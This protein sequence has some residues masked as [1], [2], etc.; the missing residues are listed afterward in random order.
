MVTELNWVLHVRAFP[1]LTVKS[2][3]YFNTTFEGDLQGKYLGIKLRKSKA[4]SSSVQ[5]PL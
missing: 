1:G 5:R 4:G 3:E 2:H